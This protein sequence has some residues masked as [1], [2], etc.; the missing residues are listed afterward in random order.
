[1]ALQLLG[2]D[3]VPL[4]LIVERIASAL[5]KR[6]P[7]SLVRIGDGENIVLAQEVV[8]SLEWIR[9]NAGWSHSPHYCG[10]ALPNPVLR[11][12]MAKALKE[13]DIVGVFA[14]DSLTEQ[15]FEALGIRPKAICYAFENL[16][17]PMYKP[18]VDLI[19]AYPPLLVG[20][21]AERFA[22]FLYDQ[23]GVKVPGALMNINSSDDIDT[24]LEEMARVPHQW[25]LVSAGVSA[26]VIAPAMA[27]KHGK[28]SID[29]GHAPDNVMSPDFPD[30]W[31][32][33]E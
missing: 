27:T 33:L 16:Y 14:R 15:V 1:M 18:F 6:E 12:R 21:P 31:L 22:A 5:A 7:F 32:T 9:H 3:Y 23:L 30:Y 2:E 8:F 10:A 29:F 20:R 26:D 19:R 13:A 24:C 17:M 25:S 4:P 28:V 11:D